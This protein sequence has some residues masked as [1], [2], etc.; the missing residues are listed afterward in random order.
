MS[1]YMA[2]ERPPRRTLLNQAVS[3]TVHPLALRVNLVRKCR[4][5]L[6]GLPGLQRCPLFSDLPTYYVFEVRSNCYPLRS[7]MTKQLFNAGTP[8][9][10]VP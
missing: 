5:K 4:E 3:G 6:A 1:A 2:R 8:S 7:V 9:P 10:C